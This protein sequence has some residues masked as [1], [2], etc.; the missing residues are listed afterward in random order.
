MTPTVKAMFVVVG[1]F[2]F[3]GI[4]VIGPSLEGGVGTLTR[5]AFGATDATAVGNRKIKADKDYAKGGPLQQ[6][7]NCC[8][9]CE[10]EWDFI[11]DRCELFSQASTACYTRCGK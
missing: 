8:E 4:S 9:Q 3:C 6:A 2:G 10:A 5:T 1:L 7:M 11:G